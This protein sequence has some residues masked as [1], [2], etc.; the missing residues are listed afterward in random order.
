MPELDINVALAFLD[1]LDPIGRHTLASEAPFGRD[2]LPKWE[3]GCTFEAHQ[4]NG[5][6]EEIRK[7][8]ARGSNIYYGVNRPCP[9]GEQRGL[10]G[11]C[12]V[13]DI[14]AIR[15]LAFDI[16]ITKRPFEH[17]HLIEFINRTLVGALRPSFLVNSGGGYQLIYVLEKPIKVAVVRP[18]ANEDLDEEQAHTNAQA[19]ADRSAITRLS[20]EFECF[21][22]SQ[23]P[24][25][26][27]NRIKIDNMSN[28]DRVMRLPGTVNYP[29]AEKRAK[30]QVD[31][32]SRV[33]IDYQCKC[34]I[35]AVRQK[36]PCLSVAPTPANRPK[37]IR[38]NKNWPN[39]RKIRIAC[40]FLKNN[41]EEIDDNNWYTYN[42]M[43]PLIS[44][45]HDPI[46]PISEEDAFDCFMEAL[47]GGKRFGVMGRGPGYFKRQSK[48]H[49]PELPPRVN[50]VRTLGTLFAQCKKR[51]MKFPWVDSV[52]WDDDFERMRKELSRP[53]PVF[54]DEELYKEI[55][56]L[57]KRGER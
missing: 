16:D 10:N 8:Q 18:A 48:S 32:L 6:I 40:D 5:L 25:S 21:L 51:G 17:E 33:E 12:N 11:K 9:V 41:V 29:K 28:V 46:D 13:D 45:I 19:R 31:A 52:F 14:I 44:A 26:L 15:A 35:F 30:K 56:A 49:H 54:D 42:V 43:F 39:T 23:A 27:M 1:G 37:I 53:G 20:Y 36:V 22:R 2:G 3:G 57:L 55:C 4:R 24:Q 50:S 34:D 38:L 7:R 47:S